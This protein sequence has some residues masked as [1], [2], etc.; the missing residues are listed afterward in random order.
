LTQ[1]P[2]AL[3]DLVAVAHFK[4]ALSAPDADADAAR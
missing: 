2:R 4:R 1:D 3:A